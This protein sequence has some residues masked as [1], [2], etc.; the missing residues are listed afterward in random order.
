MSGE[1]PQPAEIVLA[2]SATDLDA[3]HA[4]KVVVC[5]S[6]GG[7]YPALLAARYGVG[8]IVL[9]DAGVGL[10]DAGVAG[11]EVLDGHGTPAVAVDGGTARIGDA[12][13]TLDRGRVSRVNRTAERAGCAPG[14]DAREA[15]DVLARAPGPGEPVELE[16]SES[17]HLLSEGPPAVW[18]LDSAAL[19]DAGDAGAVV[20]TGSHGGLIGGEPARALKADALAA[21]FNDAGGGA[22]GPG[23]TRLPA[24]DARGIA[25]ATVAASS[26]R[27]GDGRSTYADGLLSAVNSTA[28]SLG[29]VQGMT[30]RDF[31]DLVIHKMVRT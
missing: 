30:A 1:T 12:A 9:N 19:V 6:H 28:R 13:D 15:A 11:L 5:A 31:V 17:R 26:A 22:D 25:A 7:R 14:M 8:A 10:D 20:L 24:L 3:S 23:A 21:V 29:A 2:D 4:G 27:I 16:T 18:A